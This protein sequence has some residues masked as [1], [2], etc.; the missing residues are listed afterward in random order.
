MSN[1]YSI[2]ELKVVMVRQMFVFGSCNGDYV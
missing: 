1:M 2:L